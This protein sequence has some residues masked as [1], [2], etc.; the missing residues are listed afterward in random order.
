MISGRVRET[1]RDL[2][3]GN[4]GKSKGREIELLKSLH[5]GR[6]FVPS[7]L[8]SQAHISI[9]IGML[10]FVYRKDENMYFILIGV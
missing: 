1:P 7:A 9:S 10:G 3:S 4:Q 2:L 5:Y 8:P 6:L